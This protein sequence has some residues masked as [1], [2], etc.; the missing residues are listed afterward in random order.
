MT[1]AA[2]LSRPSRNEVLWVVAAAGLIRVLYFVFYRESPFFAA[3][4]LD[5]AQHQELARALA[6]GHW[7]AGAPYFRPPLYPWLLG[8][9]QS[10]LGAGPWAGRLL[11]AAAGIAT[12]LAVLWGGAR[13]GLGRG[14]RLGAAV[15]AAL[16][17]PELFLEGAW[18]RPWAPPCMPRSSFWRASCWENPWPRRW[19]PG[20][21]CS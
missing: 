4:I 12:S 15:A 14:W 19:P 18:A 13:L 7:D 17:A 9:A 20:A 2:P 8:L 11:N 10:L 5:S 3:P 6:A 1:A 16:Y 21:W